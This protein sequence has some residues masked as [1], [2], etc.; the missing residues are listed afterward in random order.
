VDTLFLSEVQL[1]VEN[2]CDPKTIDPKR[3]NGRLAT[4]NQL[5][6]Y[7]T[8][9]L[10][11]LE[12]TIFSAMRRVSQLGREYGYA[13]THPRQRPKSMRSCLATCARVL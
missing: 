11:F 3:I 4:A 9:N 8:V 12:N 7:F 6:E 13:R 1:L 10:I 2:V 5:F